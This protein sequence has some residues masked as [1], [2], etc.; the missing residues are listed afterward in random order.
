MKNNSTFTIL[1]KLHTKVNLLSALP[2][3]TFIVM[4]KSPCSFV[5]IKHTFT[6]HVDLGLTREISDMEVKLMD[7][8][9]CGCGCIHKQYVTT[10]HVP[11]KYSLYI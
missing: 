4:I 9:Y 2:N 7:R 10:H 8:Y 3:T 1:Y 11:T 6:L 5:R